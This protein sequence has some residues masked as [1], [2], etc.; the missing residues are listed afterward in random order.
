MKAVISDQAAIRARFP[1]AILSASPTLIRSSSK[2]A[3]AAEASATLK[4]TLT[5]TEG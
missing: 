3:L 5:R 2:A 4:K 1:Q